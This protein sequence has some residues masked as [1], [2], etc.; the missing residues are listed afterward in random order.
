[1]NSE[2]LK[3]LLRQNEGATLEFKREWYRLD[4]ADGEA[5]KRQ[6]D[7]LIKDV[8][9]LVNGNASVAGEEAHLVIGADDE[10]NADGIREL[11]DVSVPITADDILKIVT[12]VS[13]FSDSGTVGR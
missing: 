6:K 3:Q 8:L 13:R 1:L 2:K 10:L 5:K 11:H 9:S 4:D 12:K 7:E